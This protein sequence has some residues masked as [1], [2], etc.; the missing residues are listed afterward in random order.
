MR[1]GIVGAG[2]VGG[3]FGCH[4]VENGADVTFIVR[5]RRKLHIE[6]NGLII[7]SP[8]GDC[9]MPVSLLSEEEQEKPLI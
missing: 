1:I 9:Q 3:Y 5:T 7:H 2:A 8:H 4:L 6:K